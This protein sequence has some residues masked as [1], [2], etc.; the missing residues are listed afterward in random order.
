MSSILETIEQTLSA[1]AEDMKYPFTGGV[2][3]GICTAQ[4]LDEWNF[5]VFERV[6]EEVTNDKS[7]T[8]YY[9]VRVVHEDYVDEDYTFEVVKAL[10]EA[11]PG[12]STSGRIKYESRLKGDTNVRVEMAV[13]PL[14]K[15][16]KI[17]V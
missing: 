8:S 11:V 10:K 12:L 1:L 17:D 15:A 4:H 13:I 5:F 6:E 14:K 7:V 2:Y 9:E 3:Y 16:R